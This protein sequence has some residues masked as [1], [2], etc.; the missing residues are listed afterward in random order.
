MLLKLLLKRSMYEP[1]AGAVLVFFEQHHMMHADT[2]RVK[3]P[4]ALAAPAMRRTPSSRRVDWAALGGRALGTTMKVMPTL[5]AQMVLEQL[6]PVAVLRGI[7]PVEI[8]WMI[9]ATRVTLLYPAKDS[10]ALAP[11]AELFPHWE[12]SSCLRGTWREW[13]EMS[14]SERFGRRWVQEGYERRTY[15]LLRGQEQIVAEVLMCR[16]AFFS[17]HQIT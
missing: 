11:A 4:A 9:L 17:R 3:T 2:I 16:T 10:V 13:D 12:D 7:W 8:C 6:R 14:V 5:K 15:R 1:G